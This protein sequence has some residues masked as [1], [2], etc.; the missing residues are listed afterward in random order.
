MRSSFKFCEEQYKISNIDER[1]VTVIASGWLLRCASGCSFS[2]RGLGLGKS[3]RQPDAY[4]IKCQTR[5]QAS[6]V[7]THTRRRIEPVSESVSFQVN[8]EIRPQLLAY[9]LWRAFIQKRR[10]ELKVLARCWYEWYRDPVSGIWEVCR[11]PSS[12]TP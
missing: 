6:F 7:P 2:S 4:V 5:P 8:N 10:D 11:P 3:N 1:F 9:L 12:S